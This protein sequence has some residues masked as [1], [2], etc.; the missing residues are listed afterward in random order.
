MP[1]VVRRSVLPLVLAVAFAPLA[2]AFAPLSARAGNGIHPRTPVVWPDDTPCMTV[3]DRSQAAT[4]QFSYGIPYEDTDTTSDEVADSRRHQFIAFCRG[5]SP[6]DP[7]PTWLSWKDVD[8]AA[9]KMLVDPMDVTD[10]EVLETSSVYKDCFHRITAD[11]ARRPIVFAEAMKPV[12]WDTMGLPAGPYVIQAYT[13]EPAFNIWTQRPGVVHVVD[14]PD[15]SKAA[16]AAALTNTED[17]MF[18]ADTLTLQ[19]CARAMPGST[20]SLSWSL[21]SD[22]MLNWQPYVEGVALDGDAIS[23]PFTPPEGAIQQTIALKLDITDPMQ[24]TF[25]TYPIHLLTVLPG[26]TGTTGCADSGSFIGGESCGEAS[27]GDATA[28]TGGGGGSSSGQEPTS[29]GAASDAGSSSGSMINPVG[30]DGCACDSGGGAGT[31]WGTPWVFGGLVL[32][33]L[34]RRRGK[35]GSTLASR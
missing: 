10:D 22:P 14:G 4:L 5:H 33:G 32:L 8:A 34:G 27:S 28:T 23:L 12:V 1:V 13:W 7:L 6:Q 16:P 3:V 2:V 20:M 30:P 17:F 26:G 35:R 24:R 21:T 11:D 31:P 18:G 19:G 9:A 29:S 25:T 15:L